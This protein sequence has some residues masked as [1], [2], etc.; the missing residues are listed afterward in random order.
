MSTGAT[1]MTSPPPPVAGPR[2]IT[3]GRVRLALESDLPVL[4]DMVERSFDSDSGS[5]F[6]NNWNLIAAA[7]QEPSCQ[8]PRR[9]WLLVY[10][11]EPEGIIAAYAWV[12][13]CGSWHLNLLEVDVARRRQGIGRAFVQQLLQ[14]VA[15]ETSADWLFLICEP[16]TSAAFWRAQGW[17][18]YQ[19]SHPQT[20]GRPVPRPA[21]GFS[22]KLSAGSEVRECTVRLLFGSGAWSDPCSRAPPATSGSGCVL[23]HKDLPYPQH[24]VT[25]RGLRTARRVY[26]PEKVAEMQRQNAT[27]TKMLCEVDGKQVFFGHVMEQ[28]RTVDEAAGL[29]VCDTGFGSFWLWGLRLYDGNPRKRRLLMSASSNEPAPA[30][31][32]R[33][34]SGIEA[35][36]DTYRRWFRHVDV[37]A[38]A[39]EYRCF[40]ETGH[41]SA[42][43][44]YMRCLDGDPR[45]VAKEFLAWLEGFG[46]VDALEEE[47]VDSDQEGEGGLVCD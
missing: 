28:H 7:L 24:T 38:L 25:L 12:R 44:D 27:Y 8:K 26:F 9:Q 21:P 20:M 31:M 3:A 10:E 35:Y 34:G 33:Y 14:Y 23:W 19:G 11:Q 32:H 40:D 17:L 43:L 1:A 42:P 37:V 6:K 4:W 30:G 22:A 45:E 39:Q 18:D 15:Q 41:V 29:G 16:G 5:G 46:C 47:G 2:A 36:R 13:E